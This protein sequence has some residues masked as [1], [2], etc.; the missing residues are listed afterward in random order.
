[1]IVLSLF[2]PLT[3]QINVIEPSQLSSQH[4]ML[5]EQMLLDALLVERAKLVLHL[6]FNIG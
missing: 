4:S 5:E 3:L 1:M 6:H 2:S